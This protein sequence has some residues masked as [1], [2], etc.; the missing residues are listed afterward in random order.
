MEPMSDVRHR[1]WRAGRR[2]GAPRP[3]A[4]RRLRRAGSCS[5]AR[6]TPPTS[7][8]RCRRATCSATTRS[9]TPFVHAGEWYAEHDVDLRLGVQATA[10]RHRRARG[11]RR[12]RRPS[13]LRPA[14]AR[15]RG[16][17]APA[18]PRRAR[19]LPVCVPAH[20]RGQRPARGRLRE[21]GR[22]VGR[23]RRLDR[24]GGGRGRPAAGCDVT[25]V[26]TADLPLLRVLG[27]EV[28][29]VFADLH[30]E[31]RRRPP[32]GARSATSTGD[33]PTTASSRPTARVPADLVVVGVGVAPNV[34][35]AEAAGLAV[36]NGIARRRRAAHV[37]AERPRRRRRRQP[38][39]TR[40]SAGGSGSSTGPTRS[41]QAR[42]PRAAMLGGRRRY[43]RMPYFFTDQYDLGME[44]VGYAGP[45]ATTR[46]SSA[47]TRR[48]ASSWRSGCATAGSWRHERQRLG[49]DRP[50]PGAGRAERSTRAGC[51]TRA[52]RSPSWP[53]RR[54]VCDAPAAR[55]AWIA[56]ESMLQPRD[57]R[58]VRISSATP[59][60][61]EVAL[62]RQR[63]PA[64]RRAGVPPRARRG[65]TG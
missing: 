36:D 51:G 24:S 14:A 54:F 57:I 48:G 42:S 1:R 56:D 53:E 2:Q 64:G 60:P 28:A 16:R 7:G 62:T 25:V 50:D 34:E 26:E 59:R 19:A 49:R 33:A 52:S 44:Y 29:T 63:A 8:R 10:A 3:C 21:G 61:P 45:G 40:C 9:T 35:L 37:G 22:M 43:D 38:T 41:T 55:S 11:A 20:R 39:C 4:P 13:V 65:R 5:S 23:R 17:A 58:P 18:G 12:R 30:R 27:A 47:A 31:P 6:S 46:S 15:H 32:L